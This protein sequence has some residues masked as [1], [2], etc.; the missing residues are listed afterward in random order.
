MTIHKSKGLEFPVVFVAGMGKRFNMM[1][2]RKATIIDGEHGVGCDYIKLSMRVCESPV[3]LK[4]Y[5]ECNGFGK[6]GRRTPG[7][8]CG[9]DQSKRKTV[10]YRSCKRCVNGTETMDTAVYRI[11]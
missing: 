2:A 1:D 6:S 10:Y 7:A 3:F 8:I 5:R 9:V 4:I 11:L